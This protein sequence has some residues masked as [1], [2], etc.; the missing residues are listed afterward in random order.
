[1][2]EPEK[3]EIDVL[4]AINENVYRSSHAALSF[5][6]GGQVVAIYMNDENLRFVFVKEGKRYGA[7]FGVSGDCCS[8]SWFHDFYNIDNLF[9]GSITDWKV[10]ELEP[11]EECMC[12]RCKNGEFVKYYG[13]QLFTQHPTYGEVTS[14]FSFRNSSNGYYGGSLELERD[15]E[16][17]PELLTDLTA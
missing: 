12:D 11:D 3:K 13:Y 2:R 15:R 16:I 1:M 10:K 9:N 8:C 14:V 6:V 17:S 5:M 7:T 4:E